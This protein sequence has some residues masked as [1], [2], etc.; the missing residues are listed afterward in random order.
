MEKLTKEK[1]L[2][3][4][5]NIKK[6]ACDDEAAHSSEDALLRW[7]VTCVANGSYSKAEAIE[8]AKIVHSV[9]EIQ[10]ERWCA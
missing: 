9:S 8:V 5:E 10:F 3:R 2:K 1:A 4:V 7:F 6:M